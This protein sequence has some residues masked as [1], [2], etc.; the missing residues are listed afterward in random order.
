V[1]EPGLARPYK[2][3]GYPVTPVLFLLVSGFMIFYLLKTQPTKSLEG[4]GTVILGLL[5]YFLAGGTPKKKEET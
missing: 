3:W 4:L 5:F 1:R 2:T